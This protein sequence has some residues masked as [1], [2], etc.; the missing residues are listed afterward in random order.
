MLEDHN[1]FSTFSDEIT[2]EVVNKLSVE[3]QAN[4]EVVDGNFY[5]L[6]NDQSIGYLKEKNNRNKIKTNERRIEEINRMV[7]QRS[8]WPY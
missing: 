2:L 4:L 6:T 1:M 5:R 3:D 7:R 8:R